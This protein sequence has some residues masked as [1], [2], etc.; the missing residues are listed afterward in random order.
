M[1]MAPNSGLSD[2]EELRREHAIDA[3]RVVFVTG[4]LIVL[5]VAIIHLVAALR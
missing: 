5:V 3:R 2:K 1:S 4:G